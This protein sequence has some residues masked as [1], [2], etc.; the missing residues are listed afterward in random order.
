MKLSESMRPVPR[1]QGARLKSRVAIWS[2]AKNTLHHL[3]NFMPSFTF[4]PS[5]DYA[6]S[7]PTFSCINDI[8]P[9]LDGS[10]QHIHVLGFHLSHKT[11]TLNYQLW[12]QCVKKYK[13]TGKLPNTQAVFK[14]TNHMNEQMRFS[15]IYH[16]ILYKIIL[17]YLPPSPL[18]LR[19]SNT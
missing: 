9:S 18:Y 7:V 5:F 2:H 1:A 19:P 14:V 16:F 10:P 8:L 12:G 15:L 11:K 13:I 6:L 4:I 3:Y 17:C